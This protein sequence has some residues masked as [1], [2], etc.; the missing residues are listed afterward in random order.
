MYVDNVNQAIV[1]TS[2]LAYDISAPLGTGGVFMFVNVG[3]V[4]ISGS[5]FQ[6]IGPGSYGQL[7]YSACTTLTLSLSSSVLKCYNNAYT[8]STNL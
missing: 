4:T 3:G 1:V 8:Y 5:T 6:R 2:M 7:I